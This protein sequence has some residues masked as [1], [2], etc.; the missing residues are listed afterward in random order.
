MKAGHV[1]DRIAC[2]EFAKAQR[3]RYRSGQVAGNFSYRDWCVFQVSEATRNKL[4]LMTQRRKEAEK[5]TQFPAI[6]ESAQR[7]CRQV[8]RARDMNAL[9]EEFLVRSDLSQPSATERERREE[10]RGIR[11]QSAQELRE[12]GMR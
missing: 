12:E 10:M 7:E 5:V 1:L 8:I 11:Q 2:A 6:H 4:A 9:P 3:A